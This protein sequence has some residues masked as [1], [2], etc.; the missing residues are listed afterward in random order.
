MNKMK[1]Y[2]TS[3]NTYLDRQSYSFL[4]TS[5]YLGRYS[6]AFASLHRNN[7]CLDPHYLKCRQ[8]DK[9]HISTYVYTYVLINVLKVTFMITA[10]NYQRTNVPAFRYQCNC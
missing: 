1:G 6:M 4:W 8:I 7:E 10:A 9:H 5:I 2:I 3:I